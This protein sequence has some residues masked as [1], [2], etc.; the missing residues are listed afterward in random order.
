MFRH[1]YLGKCDGHL[2]E[3]IRMLRAIVH[4]Q[5]HN[6]A[7]LREVLLFVDVD[8]VQYKVFLHSVHVC[9]V[10]ETDL[11]NNYKICS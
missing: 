11:W 4:G 1:V 7:V 10:G 9:P 2:V 8:H 3:L 5:S 6:S